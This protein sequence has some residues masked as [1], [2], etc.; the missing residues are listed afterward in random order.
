LRGAA[1]CTGSDVMQRAVE[2][3]AP[4]HTLVAWGRDEVQ[5]HRETLSRLTDELIAGVAA[6]VRAR[7]REHQ[8]PPQ[9]T[10]ALYLVA[11]VS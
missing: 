5:V 8:A 3:C 7:V 10:V 4:L 6:A 2:A 9:L 1:I 11:P